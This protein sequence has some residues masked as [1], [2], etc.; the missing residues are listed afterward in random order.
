MSVPPLLAHQVDGSGEPLL[1]LNGGMMS[2][3][4]WDDFIPRLTERY[5]V[6]RCDFRGQLRSPGVPLA[7]FPGHAED[8]LR[9]L[10]HLGVGKCHVAGTSYGAFAG[11]HLAVL[12]PERVGT[13]VAMTVADRVS[14]DMWTEAHDMAVACREALAGGPREK[15][16]D[17]ISAFAFSAEWAAAH[18]PEISARRGLVA[19][20][21][22]AW[23]EGLAG[24]LSA[25]EGLGIALLVPRVSCPAL[26]LLA[27]DDRAMPRAGGEALAK[28]LAR[29]EL[30]VVPG[31]GHALVVEKP[32]E[33]LDIL[34]AFLAC[35][36][37]VGETP[38]H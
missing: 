30:A 9:L 31:S 35:H 23:F 18:E 15:V 13:L 34:L 3:S 24:L 19:H 28:G 37:L 16:Y 6:V 25:L 10:D 38:A 29:G 21:P 8:L 1:L 17:L 36:P 27:G 33:T 22:D 14:D 5:R 11:F 20:L 26:V 32:R 2:F 4:A 7:G 12:A